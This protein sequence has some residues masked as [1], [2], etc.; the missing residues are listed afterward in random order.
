MVVTALE[1][2]LS[3]NYVTVVLAGYARYY[4]RPESTF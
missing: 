2:K 1:F 3:H 4:I